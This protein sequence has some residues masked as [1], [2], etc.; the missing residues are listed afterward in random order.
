M[1]PGFPYFCTPES[2]AR[3]VIRY[4]PGVGGG[5]LQSNAASM[6]KIGPFVREKYFVRTFLVD[7]LHEIFWRSFSLTNFFASA[8]FEQTSEKAYPL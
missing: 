1:V 2:P 5:A 4:M 7:F 3:I 8:A 6:F